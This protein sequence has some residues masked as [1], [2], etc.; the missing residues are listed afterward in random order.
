MGRITKKFFT[1]GLIWTMR[2]SLI[3]GMAIVLLTSLTA[4]E[5]GGEETKENKGDASEN[6]EWYEELNFGTLKLAAEYED[7][8]YEVE[9]EYN[10]GEPEAEIEDTRDDEQVIN[11]GEEA[12]TELEEILPELEL[13]NE[14][15]DEEIITEVVNVFELE[16]DYEELKV[17]IEFLEKQVEVE[18]E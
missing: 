4:C 17:E 2:K 18:D 13:T 7:G 9:Y 8:E 16:E 1:K 11:E 6:T 14:S 12:L 5:T 10:E 15:T 3:G